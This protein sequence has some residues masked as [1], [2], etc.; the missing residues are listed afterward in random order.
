[1]TV[2]VPVL[3]EADCSGV[4]W[5][6]LAFAPFD[7]GANDG[8]IRAYRAQHLPAPAPES[9]PF[10]LMGGT[11]EAARVV[12]LKK[13]C[14]S[15]ESEVN[16]RVDWVLPLPDRDAALRWS[17][18]LAGTVCGRQS[19]ACRGCSLMGSDGCG[20]VETD[21]CPGPMGRYSTC[22]GVFPCEARC[23]D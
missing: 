8:L 17:Q 6:H 23:C 11:L 19:A 15:F 9:A 10:Y 16:A 13:V 12:D 20:R 18:R 14:V 4:G 22:A 2:V 1:M 5:R 3:D 21:S 7:P